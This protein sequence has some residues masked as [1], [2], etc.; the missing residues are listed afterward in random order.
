MRLVVVEPRKIRAMAAARQLDARGSAPSDLKA[1]A[2][3]M[4]QK[5]KNLASMPVS[6]IFHPPG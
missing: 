4:F 5:M 3:G 6:I 2:M 1:M